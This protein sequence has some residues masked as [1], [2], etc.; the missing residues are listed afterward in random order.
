MD[1]MFECFAEV[2]RN[3]LG[4]KMSADKIEGSG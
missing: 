3:V 1:K 2:V 4:K